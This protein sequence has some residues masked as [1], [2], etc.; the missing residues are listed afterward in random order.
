M[1]ARMGICFFVCFVTMSCARYDLGVPGRGPEKFENLRTDSDLVV[2]VDAISSE[3]TLKRPYKLIG[4]NT[5]FY[6]RTVLK[7]KVSGDRLTVFHYRGDPNAPYEFGDEVGGM[8]VLEF[9]GR[10]PYLLFL[11]KAHD[12]RYVPT[13]GQDDPIFSAYRIILSMPT[14]PKEPLRLTPPLPETLPSK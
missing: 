5:E 4:Q 2:I 14:G 9:D 10:T 3:D 13:T 12:G 7:G 1:W 6:I 11:K 8:I